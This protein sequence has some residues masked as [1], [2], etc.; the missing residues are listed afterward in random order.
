MTNSLIHIMCSQ[1]SSIFGV[2]G[3]MVRVHIREKHCAS[4]RLE[5]NILFEVHYN[6][7]NSSRVYTVLFFLISWPL[8]SFVVQGFMVSVYGCLIFL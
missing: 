2:K 3:F 1:T 6:D 8:L 5:V 4:K 7:I